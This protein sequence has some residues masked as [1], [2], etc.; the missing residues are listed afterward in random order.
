VIVVDPFVAAV[1]IPVAGSMVAT[2]A[3]V[4]AHANVLPV[5]VDPSAAIATAWNC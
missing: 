2:F 3:S 4:E 1:A 5:I